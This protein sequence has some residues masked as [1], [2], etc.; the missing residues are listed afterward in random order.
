M[1]NQKKRD[2]G[3]KEGEE[4]RLRDM[5]IVKIIINLLFK[6]DNNTETIQEVKIINEGQI[7]LR[8]SLKKGKLLNYSDLFTLL[9]IYIFT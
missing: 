9:T 1:P 6:R 5:K 7:L 4:S 3:N 8:V 2:K